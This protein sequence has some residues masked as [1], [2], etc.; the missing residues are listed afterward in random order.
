M[1]YSANDRRRRG[2]VYSPGGAGIRRA[3]VARVAPRHDQVTE[4]DRGTV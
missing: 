3:A 2:V 4:W 1:V